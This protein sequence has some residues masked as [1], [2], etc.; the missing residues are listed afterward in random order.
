[1]GKG[2]KLARSRTLG[3]IAE[4]PPAN[5]WQQGPRWVP[6]GTNTNGSPRRASRAALG[7][8]TGPESDR[9]SVSPSAASV[10]A[11]TRTLSA[12]SNSTYPLEW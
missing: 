2:R 3:P 10:K 6:P 9:H 1:M 12:A 5:G 7:W 11:V 4:P 8:A